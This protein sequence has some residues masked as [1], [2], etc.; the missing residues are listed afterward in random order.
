VA[1]VVDLH[2]HILPGVDDGAPDLEA[3]VAMARVAADD[4][5]TTMVATPHIRDD[6]PFDHARIPGLVADLNAAL[7]SAGVPVTV[8]AGGE[9]ALTTTADLEPDA[10][11]VYALG[12]GPYLLVESPYSEVGELVER[13]LFDVQ[14]KGL[15]P[16]LAHPERSPSFLQD[17]ERL[18]ALVERGVLLSVTAD[19]M[20]GRFGGTVAAFTAELFRAGLVH[21]VASDAH[22]DRKRAPRLR[23]GFAA[24]DRELPGLADQASWFTET[25][26]RALLAGA[27]PP[28]P[29]QPPQPPGRFRRLLRRRR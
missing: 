23:H 1:P 24:L 22:D 3:A 28:A 13:Q 26:P 16:V 11:R 2:T 25:S 9:V 21:D 10:L 29:P 19:S 8:V 18:R 5:I 14:M 27:E 17:L 4:G 7:G 12:E 20:A 6:H 15:K